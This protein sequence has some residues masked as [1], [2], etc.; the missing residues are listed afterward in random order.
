[1]TGDRDCAMTGANTILQLHEGIAM[2]GANTLVT[3]PIW[4]YKQVAG[5]LC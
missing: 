2:I 1:M 3:N 5:S 4:L